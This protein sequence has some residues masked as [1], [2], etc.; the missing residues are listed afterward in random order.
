MPLFLYFSLFFSPELLFYASEKLPIFFWVLFAFEL[1]DFSYL[2][3]VTRELAIAICSQRQYYF[4][5]QSYG[6][7]NECLFIVEEEKKTC[8][9][10]NQKWIPYEFSIWF[11]S[12]SSI[13]ML[14]R[15]CT[16][17]LRT[18]EKHRF[19]ASAFLHWYIVFG[20]T[21]R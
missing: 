4:K 13:Q 14:W 16:C 10:L 15:M 6:W 19:I 12:H 21:I 8:K 11:Q 5:C 2:D 20:I 7:G 1:I 18:N 9:L 17:E 3:L